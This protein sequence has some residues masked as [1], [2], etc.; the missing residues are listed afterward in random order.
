MNDRDVLTEHKKARVVLL[1]GFLGAG[2]TTLMKQILSW[3]S[4]MSDT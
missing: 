2:K 4:D 1:A 3:K